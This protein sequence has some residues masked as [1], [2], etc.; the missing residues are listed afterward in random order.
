MWRFLLFSFTFGD[1]KPP[2]SLHFRISNFKSFLLLAKFHQLNK[3]LRL[4]VGQRVF[5]LQWPVGT[6]LELAATAYEDGRNRDRCGQKAGNGS[7]GREAV[8]L[9]NCL[10][11]AVR[12]DNVK[13]LPIRTDR[14]LCHM[15]RLTSAPGSVFQ[16]LNPKVRPTWNGVL[17]DPNL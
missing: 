1:W 15:L 14:K 3:G 6:S 16:T 10:K 2:K 8:G 11:V 17:Q 12:Y 13:Q 9:R 7:G 4:P 5:R